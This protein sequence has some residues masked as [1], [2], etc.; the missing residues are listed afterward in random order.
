MTLTDRRLALAD[1]LE[2]LAR[3]IDHGDSLG[4]GELDRMFE[5]RAEARRLRAEAHRNTQ[6]KTHD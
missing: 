4:P 5:A 1:S 2:A 6:G 3:F